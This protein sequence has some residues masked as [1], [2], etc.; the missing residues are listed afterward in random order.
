MESNND[1]NTTYYNGIAEFEY[2]L[3]ILICMY[4]FFK[5]SLI[6]T[7]KVHNFTSFSFPSLIYIMHKKKQGNFISIKI[8]PYLQHKKLEKPCLQ[9]Q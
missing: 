8:F 5:I 1:I 2:M 9:K 6:K 3:K 4:F 7:R